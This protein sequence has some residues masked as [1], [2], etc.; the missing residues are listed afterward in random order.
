MFLQRLMFARLSTCFGAAACRSL[1]CENFGDPHVLATSSA[2]HLLRV[3]DE[4]VWMKLDGIDRHAIPV[5][6]WR[7]EVLYVHQSKAGTRTTRAL[8]CGGCDGWVI[9]GRCG[10]SDSNSCTRTTQLLLNVAR[11]RGTAAPLEL[12]SAYW[13]ACRQ[14]K[15][16]IF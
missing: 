7:Q 1:P 14:R 15:H 4:V 12:Y 10:H 8:C 11:G 2:P 9:G 13:C 16:S 3:A 5:Q 6:E